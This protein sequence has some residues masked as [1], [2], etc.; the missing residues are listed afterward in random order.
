MKLN[1]SFIVALGL[2]SLALTACENELK[3]DAELSVNV[4]TSGD[5]SFDGKTIT[6]KAGTPVTFQ[7]GGDPDYLT[8]FS[9]EAGAE[10][11]NRERTLVDESD[12]ESSLFTVNIASQFGDP[13]DIISVLISE[14]CPALT[15]SDFEA[16]SVAVENAT[17]Q[18]LLPKSGFPTKVNYSA[19]ED[20]SAYMNSFLGK[21]VTIAI[22][23]KGV[24]NAAVQ[25]KFYFK[26]MQIQNVMKN[27]QVATLSAGSFGFTALNMYYRHPDVL[28]TASR[29][30]VLTG[31]P[32]AT[33]TNN[34]SG[35]WNLVNINN[36]YIHSSPKAT[37]L[38]YA[39]LVSSP[40]VINTCTPDAGTG[41]KN[42][43]QGTDSYT[44]T[45]STAGTYTATFVAKNANFKQ[46][47]SV[48]REY[49]VVVTE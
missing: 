29:A 44:H 14:D 38:M 17:W 10:Y 25:S 45:Y 8:F 34:T 22:C 26:N 48:V 41:L 30:S 13:T 16:D 11:K 31:K 23:Y 27:G 1:K 21:E 15:K 49:T 47:T 37:P 9:G 18:E 4:E 33:V 24:S 3:Q 19:G 12:I 43:S 39:W 36:F 5:V 2:G 6:V 35:M 7:F 20:Y 40:M 46:Q 42:I 32:Y 28:S